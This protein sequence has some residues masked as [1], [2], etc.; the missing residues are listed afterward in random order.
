[1]IYTITLNPAI[2][3]LLHL[4]EPLTRGLTNR[5]QK[6][7][8]DLGGKGLHVSHTLSKLGIAN[9][10]LGFVGGENESDLYSILAEKKVE[11]SM[12]SIDGAYTR[13]AYVILEGD[14]SG[15]LMMAEKG[16]SVS[17]EYKNRLVDLIKQKVTS[18]DWVVIA[19][20]FPENYSI[21][22]FEELLKVLKDIGCFVG[23]D[24][25]NEALK[26]AV[27]WNVDF[28]KPN[29]HEIKELISDKH[30]IDES[31]LSLSK[32]VKYV[33]NSR[34]SEGS[35]LAFN[36]NLYKAKAPNVEEV[37]DT[38]AGDCFVGGF[39]GALYSRKNIEDSL[40]LAS[41]IAASKVGQ[42]DCSS[43]D[44]DDVHEYKEQTIVE[45]IGGRR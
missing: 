1:M 22:D 29:E 12:I 33:I 38:G 34:G 15:S 39:V 40:K 25:S 10:A 3:R 32:K 31:L 2:D 6:T 14:K 35:Y 45:S 20:S 8:F 42:L 11:H 36:K 37:N 28:I 5:I 24:V 17:D 41:A 7:Q 44:L 23:C 26:K 18:E 4:D 30:V 9:I 21:H 43:F 16:F 13:E 19:G 27:E